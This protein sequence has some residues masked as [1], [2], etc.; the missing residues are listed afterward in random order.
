MA[1][2][3]ITVCLKRLIALLNAN[4]GIYSATVSGQVGAFPSQEEINQSLFEAD[5]EVCVRGYLQSANDSLS[6]P[7]TVTSPPLADRANIPFH[8]GNLNKVEIS[9]VTENFTTM[10][11]ANQIPLAAHALSTG[12]I[13]SLITTGTLPTGLAVLTDYYVI[14][15]N[16]NV[17]SMATTLTNALDGIGVPITLGTGTG[18]HT[19]IAWQIGIQAQNLDDVTNAIS[20]GSYVQP[21][22][23]NTLYAI[24]DAVVYF[25]ATYCRVSYGVYV[26]TGSLQAN[27]TETSLLI[28]TAAKVLAKNASAALF[29]D[30][31]QLSDMG[32]QQL[33]TDGVY[34]EQTEANN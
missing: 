26:R 9:I 6:N 29:A 10:T 14:V 17:I 20:Y 32:I 11:V 25:P 5:N 19:I 2:A 1:T 13:V 33:V 34:S 18:T 28:F 27:E 30:Y 21:D 31:S 4:P 15:I 12:Q 24:S 3:D 23:F 16:A 8:H 22:A 7:F